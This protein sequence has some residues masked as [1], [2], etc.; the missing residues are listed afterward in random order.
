M[1][2]T[3]ELG[4]VDS[5]I[6]GH[7]L[8]AQPPVHG[9]NRTPAKTQPPIE[10]GPRSGPTPREV[11][12]AADVVISIVSPPASV[13]LAERVSTLGAR[14]LDAPVSGSVPQAKSGTRTIMAGGEEGAFRRAEPVLRH[15]S[16]VGSPLLI[17]S[18]PLLP[19]LSERACQA[20][21]RD[22]DRGKQSRPRE[23]EPPRPVCGPDRQACAPAFLPVV[24]RPHASISGGPR[25]ASRKTRTC[26]P[27]LRSF[28][29]RPWRVRASS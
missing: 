12:A 29:G 21:R 2:T 16:A 5:Q 13:E 11:T 22:N 15:A 27:A 9:T 8:A 14:M 4:A 10:R 25:P 20:E 24:M 19:D 26:V 7:P 6:A 17:A 1:S 28:Y 23:P 18:V 3:I